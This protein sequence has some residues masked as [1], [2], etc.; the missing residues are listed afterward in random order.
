MLQETIY[1]LLRGPLISVSVAVCLLGILFQIIRFWR[2]SRQ[3]VGVC[4]QPDTR[5][6]PGMAAVRPAQPPAFKF[7]D[8][9]QT[10]FGR[11]PVMVLVTTLFHAGLV[12]APVFVLG[13]SVLLDQSWG[14]SVPCFSERITDHLTILVLGACL[15]F[16][17]RRVLLSRVRALSSFYDFFILGLVTMP[18][19]TGF[20][21]YHQLFDHRTLMML[22]MG[23]GELLIMALP[24]TKL[25]HAVYFFI[26][27]F[28]VGGEHSFNKK[29]RRVWLPCQ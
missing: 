13:H 17:V 7:A 8:L 14:F 5:P 21:A 10:A 3:I 22:H 2:V 25:M 23:A 15:F 1:E 18:F 20:L 4:Y 16:L 19:L 12:L 28:L 27:R 24:F 26:N 11:D 29:G 9:R 6:T